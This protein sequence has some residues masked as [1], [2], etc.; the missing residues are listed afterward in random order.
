M[1]VSEPHGVKDYTGTNA[2]GME[3]PKSQ[4]LGISARVEVVD[5]GCCK[6]ED[7]V[8]IIGSDATTELAKHVVTDTEGPVRAGTNKA[9]KPFN[10]TEEAADEDS[11]EAVVTRAA[12]SLPFFCA[13]K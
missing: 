2:Q 1:D 4:A 8:D 13:L 5:N 12:P 10:N 11:R 3:R 7:V 6:A 9:D